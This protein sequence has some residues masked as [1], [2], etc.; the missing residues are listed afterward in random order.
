MKTAL[1]SGGTGFLGCW[2]CESLLEEGHNVIALDNLITSN[3][4]NLDHL[5]K[6]RTFQFVQ[7]NIV[8]P[9]EVEQ[10]IDYVFHLASRASPVDFAKYPIEILQTNSVGTHLM[11]KL[12]KEKKAR[13]LLSSTSEV[14]G[15]P[16]EYPQK[17]T[18]WGNVNSVGPRSCYDESKRYA[19]A[20]TMAFY[21][22]YNI[23]VRIVRIF[24]T[25]G[26]RM[27]KNDGRIVPNFINMALEGRDIIVHG[28][29]T[30]TR[31]FCY[32]SDLV[33]GIKKTMFKEGVSGEV[34]NLGNPGEYTVLTVANLIKKLTNSNSN[35]LFKDLPIDD[36]V[37][38]RPDITKALETLKWT[39]KVDFE[40]GLKRTIAW[41]KKN[42]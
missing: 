9:I 27:R 22:Q 33:D 35:I 26:P 18:Y 12:A 15:D 8:E 37:R 17:E 31:S 10:D 20:L 2:L 30:Q 21:R 11:L 1:V 14:Y 41:F 39:P 25:Y 28:D 4:T 3:P 42:G 13:F 29:G 40:E 32:V 38:R 19:E 24:N 34:F 5:K 7:H 16:L 36:P 23:D 6:Y